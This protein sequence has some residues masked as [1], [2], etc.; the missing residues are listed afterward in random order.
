[1]TKEHRVIK[2]TQTG[3]IKMFKTN[4]KQLKLLA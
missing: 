2:Y 3:V 4:Q 1:M